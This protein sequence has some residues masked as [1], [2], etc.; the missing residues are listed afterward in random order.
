[1]TFRILI[2]EGEGTTLEFKESLSSSFAR[3]LVALANTIGGKILLGVRDDG[4]VAG[5]VIE[6]TPE[7]REELV[8]LLQKGEELSPAWSRILFPPEK[9]EY[10]L[11]YHGKEREEDI[12][13]D[14]LAV[15]LQPVRTFG[16][17][18]VGG[19]NMLIF[20]DNLQAMKALLE[21]KKAGT[22]SR[23]TR[24]CACPKSSTPQRR[25]WTAPS[26]WKTTMRS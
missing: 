2:Q 25:S 14:T 8:R 12:L 21:M 3:E 15:P 1:M 11:V 22:C 7:Q 4:T 19:H 18:G 10:E 20:G 9:R 23:L 6:M 5:R 24:R 13:A 16:D 26:V 17:N